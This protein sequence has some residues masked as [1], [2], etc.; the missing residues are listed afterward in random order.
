[1]KKVIYFLSIFGLVGCDLSTSTIGFINQ[2]Q[3][4]LTAKSRYT[5]NSCYD[6]IVEYRFYDES[7]KKIFYVDD[8]F[9][10][11]EEEISDKVEY[12]DS[13]NIVLYQNPLILDCSVKYNDND[14]ITL[15]CIN[16][17]YKD[18]EGYYHIQRTLYPTK[19]E[20]LEHRDEDC[21]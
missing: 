20:A 19:E 14:I 6:E 15:Y 18:Q 1:M 7:Y 21:I 8:N 4:E 11:I 10:D 12:V 5:V 9:S 3:E 13:L 2:A 17:E 16:R